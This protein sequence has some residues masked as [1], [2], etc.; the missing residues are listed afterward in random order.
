MVLK[1]AQVIMLI[2][3]AG[4]MKNKKSCGYTY[5]MLLV[6]VASMA[7]MA[8]VLGGII[9]SKE[10]RI[11]KENE[12][13]FR[14]MAYAAAI[15]SYH[16]TPDSNGSFPINLEDLVKDPRFPLK[17]HIRRIY[18][19][20]ITGKD[21]VLITAPGGGIVGVASSSKTKPIKQTNF[22]IKLRKFESAE[23]YSDWLFIYDM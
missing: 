13:I 8:S 6:V 14:G 5:L 3:T 11:E 2:L 16:D 10:I 19:D 1:A 21:W 18:K 9:F 17:K 23:H 22:P 7:L 20:P 4:K 15:K 12:L